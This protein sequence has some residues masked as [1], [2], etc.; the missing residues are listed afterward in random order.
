MLSFSDVIEKEHWLQMG[1]PEKMRISANS[2]Y[3]IE[4][5]FFLPYDL[6]KETI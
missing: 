3:T 1:W 5:K 4:W 6:L 2:N